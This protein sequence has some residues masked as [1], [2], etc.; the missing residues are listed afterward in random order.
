MLNWIMDDL[1][2]QNVPKLVG[3][4]I[5]LAAAHSSLL[6]SYGVTIDW[7]TLGGKLTIA[8]TLLV[9][10]LAGHHTQ[11]AVTAATGGSN[12]NPPA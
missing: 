3:A 7:N 8:T 4:L 10:M 1:L 6:Q 12:D 2:K 9:G 11:G 5:A